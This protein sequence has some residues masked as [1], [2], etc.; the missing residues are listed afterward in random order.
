MIDARSIVPFDYSLVI[1]SVKKTRNILLSS[2]ACE[3]GSFLHTMASRIT[4]LAFDEL[5]SPPTVVGA[6]N[7]I[8]PPDEL[9]RTYSF[10]PFPSEPLRLHPPIHSSFARLFRE[11]GDG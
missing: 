11:E 10:F 8:T 4:Q 5:D 1:E 9:E 3:R 7:W 6:R 2:D